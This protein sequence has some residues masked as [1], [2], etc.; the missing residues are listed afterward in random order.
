M[1]DVELVR[2]G[3][4]G[5]SALQATFLPGAF[6]VEVQ[7]SAVEVRRPTRGLVVIGWFFVAPHPDVT[8]TEKGGDYTLEAAPGIEY[9]YRWDADGNGKPDS[10]TF[11]TQSQV[12]V[13]LEPGASQVVR[14]EVQNAFGLHASKEVT[15]TRPAGSSG[16][17]VLGQN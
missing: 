16:G 2:V 11:G 10:E 13:H 5:Y 14:L 9:G 17:L 12:K 8:V 6:D 7:D 3:F 4:A 1:V 15:L